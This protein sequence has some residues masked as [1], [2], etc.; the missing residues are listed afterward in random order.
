M[1]VAG[2]FRLFIALEILIFGG[3]FAAHVLLRLGASEWPAAREILSFPLGLAATGILLASSFTMA[4]AARSLGRK[5]VEQYWLFM[6]FTVLLALSFLF[7][8]AFEWGE[9]I[10]LGMLPWTSTYLALYFTLT[11]VHALHVLGGFA[12]NAYLLASGFTLWSREPD[13]LTRRVAAA[14][15]YWQLV[16]VA[17]LGIFGLLYIL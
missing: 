4:M 15:L 9:K 6:G 8:K 1:S 16:C 3:L 7:V 17:W 10:E 11:G 13:R 12:A 14:G 5:D 2:R